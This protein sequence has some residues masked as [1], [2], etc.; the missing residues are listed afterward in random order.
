MYVYI[1]IYIYIY[2]YKEARR[3]LA[4][5]ICL[6]RDGGERGRGGVPAASFCTSVLDVL[7][8][9][10]GNISFQRDEIPPQARGP[11]RKQDL[12]NLYSY[13][14]PLTSYLLPLPL[15][16]ATPIPIPIPIPRKRERERERERPQERTPRLLGRQRSPRFQDLLDYYLYYNYQYRYH[17]HY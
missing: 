7:P 14:L 16:V 12:R 9:L 3:T 5:G 15:P 2:I 6:S 17:Y 11:P 1:Y 13:L 8:S 4:V 10:S